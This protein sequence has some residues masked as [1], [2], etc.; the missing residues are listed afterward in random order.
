[1]ESDYSACSSIFPIIV[2]IDSTSMEEKNVKESSTSVLSISD[3]RISLAVN[4]GKEYVMKERQ[5]KASMTIE[6]SILVPLTLFIIMGLILSVF[7]FYDKNVLNGVAYETVVTGSLEMREEEI[8]EDELINLCR[9]RMGGKCIFLTNQQIEVTISEGEVSV[10]IRA[11]KSGF[12][13]SVHKR[14][15]IT[16]PEKRIRDVRRLGL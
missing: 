7:Y 11:W 5:L 14:A 6:M 3:R 8:S 4:N 12:A 13:V 16:T 10:D 15:A 2:Y 9:E 1:M